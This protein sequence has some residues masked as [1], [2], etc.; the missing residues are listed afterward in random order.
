ME[1]ISKLGL[2]LLVGTPSQSDLTSSNEWSTRAA[3][4]SNIF[5]ESRPAGSQPLV[6]DEKN[7]LKALVKIKNLATRGLAFVQ[8]QYAVAHHHGHDASVDFGTARE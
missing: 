6:G 1:P 2:R 5:H 7:S 8:Y 3:Q 4:Q